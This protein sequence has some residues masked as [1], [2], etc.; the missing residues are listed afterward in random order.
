MAKLRPSFVFLKQ[1]ELLSRGRLHLKDSVKI[2]TF[3]YN[4]HGSG[5][6]GVRSA[7][8][9]PEQPRSVSNDAVLSAGGL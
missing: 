5:S 6:S 8:L 7:R 9:L 2:I 3:T 4:T 1:L